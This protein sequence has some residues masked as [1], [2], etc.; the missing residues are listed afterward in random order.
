[1]EDSQ[2]EQITDDESYNIPL[3]DRQIQ[4]QS[5][6]PPIKDLCDRMTRGKLDVQA[7]FQRQYVWESKIELKSKLIE[8]VLLKVPIPVVYTAEMNDGKEVVVDGQQRLRTFLEFR[9]NDGFKLSK[10]KILENLNTKGYVDLSE[11]LQDKFD[12]YP[13]RVVKILKESHPD[14]KFDIFE[15]LNRGSVKLSD[16][17]LRNCMFRGNFNNLLKELIM[18]SDFLRIQNL[19][20]P[21]KRMKDKERILRFFAL[22]DKGLQNYKS[23]LRTFLSAYSEEKRE[24]SQKEVQEK[25]E[26]FKKCVEL[27]RTVFGDLAGHR[28]IKEDDDIGGYIATNF[29]DGILDA[30]MIGFVEYSKRDVI[31]KAQ[32]IKDTYTDL[33]STPSFSE[34]VEISTYST[35]QTKKRLEKWLAKLREVMNY[36][37]NDRRLYTYE[38]KTHLF[39]QKN[40]NICQICKNQIMDI[41]DA[42]VDHIERFAEGGKTT[43][44]NAQLTHRYCNLQ[45]G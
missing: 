40:G 19:S 7:D 17:E 43:I 2:S 31:P 21:E 37:S 11:D 34:T 14:I 22:N 8:S 45:K 9:K 39:E 27:C 38:E 41:N 1:M 32:V 10:L 16:Q 13:I 20:E 6:D 24:I 23:P 28:W 33:V 18:N 29:N 36:P 15:R 30:Q 25:T 5:S 4:T 35:T 12:S 26:L 44:K 42:H 3:K